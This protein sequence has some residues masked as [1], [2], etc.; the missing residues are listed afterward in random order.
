[1]LLMIAEMMYH[2]MLLVLFALELQRF[3]AK[4]HSE[5]SQCRF[6]CWRQEV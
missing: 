2:Y 3:Q 5:G 6:Y 1:M 4:S